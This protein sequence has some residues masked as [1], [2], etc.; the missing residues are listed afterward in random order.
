MTHQQLNMQADRIEMLLS[1][2]RIPGRI[3]GGVVTPRLIRFQLIPGI[4]TKLNKLKALTEEIALNLGARECRIQREEGTIHIDI[5]RRG[6]SKIELLPLCRRLARVPACAPVLGVD[7]EGYPLVLS[8]TAPEIA[9]VLI[10]GTTGSGKTVLVRAMAMSLAMHN[11]QGRLQMAMVD[12]KGRGLGVFE[13]LPH[14]MYPIASDG[15]GAASVLRDLVVEM[16]RRDEAGVSWPQI[17]VFI[18]E[19]AELVM[20][21]GEEVREMLARLTQRGREAGIHMVACTQKPLASV[22]GSLV[23]G[24][25]S[26]RVVG[27]VASAEDARVAS[28]IG[29]TGAERLG[30]HGE[31]VV[32]A[33]GEQ[34]RMQGALITE[35]EIGALVGRL[36]HARGGRMRWGEGARK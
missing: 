12:M 20:E 8:L 24:N 26:A 9:H 33:G 34:V 35:P 13:G 28:G 5:A 4:G 29:G 23:K 27:K 32:V 11:P 36:R 21:G 22:I 2:H 18:D 15:P 30:G 6:E 16:K 7:E 14:L 19:L 17:V 31:F 10:S 3:A 1:E 25:F